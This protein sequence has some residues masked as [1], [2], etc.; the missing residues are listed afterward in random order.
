MLHVILDIQHA[1]IPTRPGDMGASFDLDG[2]GV[3]GESG[4]REVDLVRVYTPAAATYVTTRG[5]RATVLESGTYGQ[6][7]ATA[8]RIAQSDPS[9]R[10]LYLAN[11]TNAGGGRYGLLRPDARSRAGAA[12]AAAL[13]AVLGRRLPELS[14]VRLD[15]L[16][17]DA[18]TAAKAGRKPFV[19]P[20]RTEDWGW[21][22]RGY[23]CID[24]IFAGPANLTA[25]LVEP[26]FI[27]SAAHR[28]L[29]TPAGLLRVGEAL[30]EGAIAWASA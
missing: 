9:A 18:A 10:C 8:V 12:A 4:E 20:D 7:H 11:H 19:R 27:D 6:R 3:R 28:A 25:V 21:W 26:L 29:T 2:D 30:G 16:Y 13:G 22:T 5:G 15:P 23:A 24:G 17:P 14:E 1:G